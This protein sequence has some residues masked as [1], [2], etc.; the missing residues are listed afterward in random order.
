MHLTACPIKSIAEKNIYKNRFEK[1]DQEMIPNQTTKQDKQTLQDENTESKRLVKQCTA[2]F[3]YGELVYNQMI[4]D[5]I[6]KSKKG[7]K[8][9]NLYYIEGM[10]QKS[11]K[12]H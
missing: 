6:I 5:N 1:N 4:K 10:I 7:T 12:E 9:V 3:L 2:V 11:P 8:I